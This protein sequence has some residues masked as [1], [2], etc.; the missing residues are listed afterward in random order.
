MTLLADPAPLDRIT[1]RQLVQAALEED[2]ANQDLTTNALIP[3]EQLGRGILTAKES[4]VICGLNFGQETYYVVE[5]RV[6]WMAACIDGTA[7]AAG[8]TVAHV[9]GPMHAILRGERV[10]LNFLQRLSGIAT[11]TA[12]AVHAVGKSQARI[13]DTRKTTPGLRVA[14]RYAVRVGGGINHRFNLSSALLIK[15]NHIAATRARGQTLADAVQSALQ[16]A[17]PATAV[18][19][20]VTSLDEL[21][22]ALEAGAR[23][24]LLDNF[25]L[26][27]LAAA[28]QVAH[29]RGAVTE[30]SGG[31]ALED[32]GAY[33][34]SGVD[35]ISL[36]AITHSAPALDI[37]L[38]IVPE[39]LE[40]DR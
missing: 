37:S 21:E 9:T 17:G 11:L 1:L 6:Q 18:E 29:A 5:P 10:A 30:A 4:G 19:V 40:E 12:E 24:V 15:D 7:V 34:E 13:L 23:A 20:E 36:G 14:E 8:A 28:V 16:A 33:A 3:H 31:I 25:E 26:G 32:V 38:N 35:F 27:A 22:E 2:G 39:A